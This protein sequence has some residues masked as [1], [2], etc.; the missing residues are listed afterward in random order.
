MELFPHGLIARGGATVGY[1][2]IG[3]NLQHAPAGAQ[4]AGY[5]TGSGPVPWSAAQFTAH[6]GTV[7][8]DQDPAASDPT[9]DVL[10]VERGAATTG[11]C[12]GWAKRAMADY[13]AATRPGQRWPAVYASAA[14]IT[15]LVNALIAGG[16]TSGVGLWVANWDLTKAQAF[17][18]VLNAAGP[19]PVVAVQWS[20]GT[21]FDTDVFSSA[22]LAH[23][24][25]ASS[26]GTAHY[27]A[28]GDTLG[29][30]AASR[31]MDVLAWL[32]LQQKLH[33]DDAHN[34]AGHATPLTHSR[35]WTEN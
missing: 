4:L 12:P 13:G 21:W 35:W 16:V 32:A 8:I 25:G 22:W 27:T 11:D 19:F 30:I 14:E 1:D 3:A 26:R 2:V 20:S 29:G 7:R 23:V 6:P 34:L 10:D 15:P 5:S 33:P 24:S 31:R 28:A 17:A 18:D 9:A